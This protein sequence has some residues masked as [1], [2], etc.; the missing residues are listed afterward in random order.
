[1]P[2]K[3]IETWMPF[4]TAKIFADAKRAPIEYASFTDLA[5]APDGV[6]FFSV[7]TA[8]DIGKAYTNQTKVDNLGR[9]LW[10]E[11]IG[12]RFHHPNPVKE[13]PASVA[14]VHAAKIFMEEIPNHCYFE[15]KTE[16]DVRLW[17]KPLMAP[18]GYGVMGQ[19]ITLVPAIYSSGFAESGWPVRGNRMKFIGNVLEI[20]STTR[21][22]ITVYFSDH[23]KQLLYALDP[24][25][26]WD[27]V[28]TSVPS[29][30]MIECSLRGKEA[31]E[32]RGDY[33]AAGSGG[34][35]E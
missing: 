10:L 28:P 20:P 11:S 22:T 26:D 34:E 3:V 35:E 31:F 4:D 7:R 29:M 18:P 19:W 9:P 27:F 30:A 23:A 12:I 25:A 16:T 17:L 1:M 5:N 13:D 21:V 32:Q 14:K 15:F 24:L 33:S 6:D 8:S 2:R